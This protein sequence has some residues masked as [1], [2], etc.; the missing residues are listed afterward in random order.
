M[1]LVKNYHTTASTEIPAEEETPKFIKK[2]T[3]DFAEY[4]GAKVDIK[5]AKNGRGKIT[6]PFSS[7]EDFNRLQKLI[8]SAK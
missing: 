8:K 2:G 4:F 3:K 1:F 6:I 7:E 5:V